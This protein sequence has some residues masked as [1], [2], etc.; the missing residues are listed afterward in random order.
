METFG[1]IERNGMSMGFSHAKFG[2]AKIEKKYYFSVF[3]NL[4]YKNVP[5][6]LI[7]KI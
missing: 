6:H 4:L 3:N 2:L 7:K 1:I 5:C